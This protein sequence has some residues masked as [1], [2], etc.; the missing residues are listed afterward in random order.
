[1]EA[2]MQQEWTPEDTFGTRLAI[3]RQRMHWNVSEAARECGL[4]GATWA[5]WE[6]LGTLPRNLYEVCHKISERTGCSYNWLLQGG[7]LASPDG[8]RNRWSY[9][10]TLRSVPSRYKGPGGSSK[11]AER[12]LPLFAKAVDTQ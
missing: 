12:P 1:M 3:V 4:K 7:P 6:D 5:T 9:R 8:V 2:A 10:R 11:R